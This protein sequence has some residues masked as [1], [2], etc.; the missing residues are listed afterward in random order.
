MT[1]ILFTGLVLHE[2]PQSTFGKLLDLLSAADQRKVLLVVLKLLSNEYLSSV[3]SDEAFEDYPIVWA[4][5]CALQAVIGDS[6][7]RK[8]QLIAWLTSTTGAGLGETCGIR[9][10]ALAVLADDKEAIF[11][12]LESSLGLLG[13]QLY[14]K[15]SPMLQ[16]EGQLVLPNT[17]GRIL[18]H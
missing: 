16:Q 12:V 17:T 9:R 7:V 15:H 18:T 6:G 13:D 3:D 14:I 2:E 10:A 1:K 5:A 11:S 4:A 8:A